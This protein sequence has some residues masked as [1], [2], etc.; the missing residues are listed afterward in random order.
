MK[1]SAI[2]CGIVGGGIPFLF[3]AYLAG[4]EIVYRAL[5]PTP[6]GTGACGMTMA[7]AVFVIAVGT[8]LGAGVFALIGWLLSGCVALWRRRPV[9]RLVEVEK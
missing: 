3:G 6:P 9:K 7:V 1:W 5:H 8:P 4:H 2:I